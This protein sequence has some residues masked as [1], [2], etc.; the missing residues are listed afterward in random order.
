VPGIHVSKPDADEVMEAVDSIPEKGAVRF[1]ENSEESSDSDF[2]APGE[3]EDASSSSES[4]F[5]PGDGG[6]LLENLDSD[7]GSDEEFELKKE[8]K[9]SGSDL[10][11]KRGF[12]GSSEDSISAEDDSDMSFSTEVAAR[13]ETEFSERVRELMELIESEGTVTDAL[14]ASS[15]N[16]E[17]AKSLTDLATRLLF[18]G[19]YDVFTMDSATLGTLIVRDG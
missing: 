14:C 13:T 2:A 5:T 18:M 15:D 16:T 17:K 19:V 3:K 12:S 11:S 4:D 9:Q 10:D 7:S 1:A 8:A 6:K